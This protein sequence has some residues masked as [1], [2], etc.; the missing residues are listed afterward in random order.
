VQ[1]DPEPRSSGA[2][3][4]L[5][6]VTGLRESDAAPAW[7][8]RAQLPGLASILDPADTTGTKNALFDRIQRKALD[9]VDRRAGQRI[10]DLGCGTGRLTGWLQEHGADILEVD[11]ALDRIEAAR[12]RVPSG[13][14]AVVDSGRI[15]VEDG[16]FDTIVSVGT[17]RYFVATPSGLDEAARELARVLPPA[18]RLVAI[19]QVQYGGLGRGG[20]LEAYQSGF[21]AAGF[22]S[23]V[24]GSRLFL[25]RPPPRDMA[26]SARQAPRTPVAREVRGVTRAPRDAR[27]RALR[28]LPLRRDTLTRSSW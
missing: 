16:T 20:T 21:G 6:P 25:A 19:E 12:A 18:G 5:V 1:R 11:R 4:T 7:A 2:D 13:R 9:V 26:T 3:A 10:L 8:D 22:Q 15:P 17:L 23:T 14:F 24:T 28:R 27:R